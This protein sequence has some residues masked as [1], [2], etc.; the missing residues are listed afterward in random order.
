MIST[1][2]RL[3]TS[4]AAALAMLLGACAGT[5]VTDPTATADEPERP[6]GFDPAVAVPITTRERLLD[7][8]GGRTLY[9]VGGDVE[10]DLVF[11]DATID[12]SIVRPGE[13]PLPVTLDWEWE[14][15]AYCRTGTVGAQPI[16]RKCEGVTLYPGVG[17][18]LDYRDADDPI[19][20]W[21]FDE[22]PSPTN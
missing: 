14:G 15:D 3:R 22:R 12:G 6:E 19:E 9:L 16:E 5:P 10:V 20:F 17:V 7:E 8:L 18:E 11:G 4:N 21:T 13:A 2:P 1:S